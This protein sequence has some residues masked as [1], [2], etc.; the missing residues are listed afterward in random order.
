MPNPD[1][2]MLD[3]IL[4]AYMRVLDLGWTGLSPTAIWLANQVA[5]WYLL[6]ALVATVAEFQHKILDVM[7]KLVYVMVYIWIIANLQFLTELYTDFVVRAFLLMSGNTMT[8]EQFKRP[9]QVILQGWTAT[10]P[11]Y[12]F[13]KNMSSSYWAAIT[14]IFAILIYDLGVLM[15]MWLCFNIMALHIAVVLILAKT[16]ALMT[17]LF[18]PFAIWSGTA[19]MAEWCVNAF[20]ASTV[21][22]GTLA[23]ITGVQM[24]WIHK[25]V[26]QPESGTL[27]LWAALSAT[28]LAFFMAVMSWHAPRFF[29]SFFGGGA[30]ISGSTVIA[31]GAGLMAAGRR[32]ASSIALA[33]G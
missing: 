1:P 2:G 10:L 23:F 31:F 32:A 33:R 9:S 27:G 20:M 13:V 14:N 17:L 4:L 25:L 29:S 3:G 16:I 15:P 26:F 24:P 22:L 11:I 8:V 12:A 18:L 7:L 30:S 21:R 19:F 5:T 28:L 6:L